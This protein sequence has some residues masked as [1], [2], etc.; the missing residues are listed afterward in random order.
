MIPGSGNKTERTGPHLSFSALQAGHPSFLFYSSVI[1]RW[2]NHTGLCS[3]PGPARILRATLQGMAS[4]S[5]P[6]GGSQGAIEEAGMNCLL[7]R[8]VDLAWHYQGEHLALCSADLGS[9]YLPVLTSRQPLQPPVCP[10]VHTLLFAGFLSLIFLLGHLQG[11]WTARTASKG[12]RE[13]LEQNR[14]HLF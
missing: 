2:R 5:Q 3:N 9:A 11:A 8:G 1:G 12:L 13:L 10:T 4:K 7:E 14:F 6:H